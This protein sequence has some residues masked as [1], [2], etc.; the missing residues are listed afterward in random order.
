MTQLKTEVAALYFIVNVIDG[1][2]TAAAANF[3]VAK[4]TATRTIVVVLVV[5]LMLM[6]VVAVVRL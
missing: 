4:V 2:V 5:V 6:A 1:T 3:T